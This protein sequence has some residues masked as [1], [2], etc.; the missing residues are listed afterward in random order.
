MNSQHEELLCVAE[1]IVR[2]PPGVVTSSTLA[3]AHE[4]LLMKW[5]EGK[6]RSIGIQDGAAYQK[7]Q[8][9]KGFDQSKRSIQLDNPAQG[10]AVACPYDFRR[11]MRAGGGSAKTNQ[12]SQSEKSICCDRSWNSSESDNVKAQW[13]ALS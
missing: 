1:R 8:T 4:V 6:K 12:W 9:P 5:R 7:I 13:K 3:F 2:G 11:L 10:W